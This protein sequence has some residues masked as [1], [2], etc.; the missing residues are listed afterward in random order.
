[1]KK[2]V[3]I[4]CLLMTSTLWSQSRYNILLNMVHHN[5]G[6][7]QFLSRYT[8]PNFISGLGY[9][10][11]VPKIEVQCGLT[12][13]K[14]K[15][16]II[17]QR[18]EERFW[19]E[20][21]AASVRMYLKRVKDA[22]LEA[23]PFTDMLVVPKSVMEKY[24]DEMKNEKGQIS[25]LRPM[26]QEI[27]RAQIDELFWRFPNLDGLVIRH[28]ETYLHDAPFHKGESPA[29]SVEEH[30][31]FLNILREEICV[32][33]NKKLYYRTWDFENLHVRP[34]MYISVMNSVQVHPNLYISI[35]HVNYDFNRGYPFNK[36]IGI[37]EHNQI[38]EVSINQA[39]CY[40]KNA[41]PYYIGKGVIE[42]W[43]D[44]DEKKGI[45]DLYDTSIVKGFWLWTWGDGWYGP[46][47]DNEFWVNLNE[48]VI[49]TYINSPQR[50][51]EEIFYDYA[52]NV[53]HLDRTSAEY[54]R[55]LCLLSEDAVFLGQDTK[56]LKRNV[57]WIRDQFLTGINLNE[58]VEKGMEN[59][60][61][62]EKRNN[63][64]RWYEMES[65]AKKIR[66]PNLEDKEFVEV[67]TIYGRIKYELAFQIWRI[68]ILLAQYDVR[69][70]KIDSM[71][72]KDAIHDYE[73]LWNSWEDLKKTY[74]CCSTLYEDWRA[75]NVAPPFQE[76]LS[77]LKSLMTKD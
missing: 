35:K 9:M 47:F 3:Y 58:V 28:G 68:Q 27:L 43:N 49:R 65:L 34:D 51:E 70:I 53:L 31:L 74:P 21:H 32:K 7:P 38:V 20:R 40:G 29:R 71:E 16:D 10:G 48:Y 30:V 39:G 59:L 72:A 18:S 54:L 66:L 8:D 11:Q 1:M 33:R 22:G 62:E 4:L 67:S 44:L 36:T 42:G 14:W 60:I 45:R 5:P 76:S 37:G 15:T 52:M 17:P 41:H 12:Y 46:Y 63:L 69:G 77:R 55:R 56:L 24:G 6:E 73:Q 64:K 61:L 19:I 57:W 2:I 26:T 23:L 25:I 50:K 75:V 13:D